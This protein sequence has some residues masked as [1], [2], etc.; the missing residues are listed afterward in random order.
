MEMEMCSKLCSFQKLHILTQYFDR[1]FKFCC[2]ILWEILLKRCLQ[3]MQVVER[4]FTNN[5][6]S[7][8]YS[9]PDNHNNRQTTDTPGFKPFTIQIACKSHQYL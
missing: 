8:D 7:E 9:H 6:L 4:S 3:H 2:E 1:L 5:S